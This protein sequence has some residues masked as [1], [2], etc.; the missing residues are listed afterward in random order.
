MR[1]RTH[2]SSATT[3]P[4]RIAGDPLRACATNTTTTAHALVRQQRVAG[5][6]PTPHGTARHIPRHPRASH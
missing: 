4:S 1:S 3:P 5:A 6:V 2:I